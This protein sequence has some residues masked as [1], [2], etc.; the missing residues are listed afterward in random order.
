MAKPS[1]T[2]YQ[3]LV[4]AGRRAVSLTFAFCILQS[5]TFSGGSQA[6]DTWQM[7]NLGFKEIENLHKEATQFA[8]RFWRCVSQNLC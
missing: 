8:G 1:D 3:A 2:T 5:S 6:S 4:W 7:E